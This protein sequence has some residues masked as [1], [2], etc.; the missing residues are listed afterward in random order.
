ME[1]IENK[2]SV[3][4]STGGVFK[5]LKSS[6]PPPL[7]ESYWDSS[8][9]FLVFLSAIFQQRYAPAPYG[10]YIPPHATQIMYSA[11][12]QPYAVAYPYQYHGQ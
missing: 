12:G 9:S 3:L 11:D 8:G 2:V 1:T 4:P 6:P 7:I 10:D 5:L